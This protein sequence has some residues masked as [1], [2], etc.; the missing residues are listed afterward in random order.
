MKKSIFS[1]II[2]AAIF[3]VP[4][5]SLEAS[6]RNVYGA[7]CTSI[8]DCNSGICINVNPEITPPTNICGCLGTW[9]C[10]SFPGT[11]CNTVHKV[12]INSDAKATGESCRSG[13]QCL[14]TLCTAGICA[15]KV[16]ADCGTG[17]TCTVS[18]G[19]CSSGTLLIQA[20]P[21]EYVAMP[22]GSSGTGT[23]SRIQTLIDEVNELITNLKARMVR[24]R[25]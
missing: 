1:L 10:S 15:C 7:A 17:K 20:A 16:N 18:T 9:D 11:V 13:T 5:L 4:I 25:L 22:S 3:L 23:P 12:C 8:D 14:S 19:R 2:I 6:A 21:R 24:L